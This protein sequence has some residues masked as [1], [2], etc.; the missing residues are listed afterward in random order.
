MSSLFDVDRRTD[1]LEMSSQAN[2]NHDPN[3]TPYTLTL[4]RYTVAIA[5]LGRL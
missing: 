3:H 1:N 5:A 4:I 2:P